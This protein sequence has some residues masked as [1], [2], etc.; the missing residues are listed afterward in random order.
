LF[1]D[2]KSN[3]PIKKACG[4]NRKPFLCMPEAR[5]ELAQALEPRD[6]KPL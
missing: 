4:I 1:R 2:E 5:I 6:F 3:E